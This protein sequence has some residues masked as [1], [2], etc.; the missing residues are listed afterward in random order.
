MAVFSSTMGR[1]N[2]MAGK[3]WGWGSVLECLALRNEVWSRSW[4]PGTLESLAVEDPKT[5]ESRCSPP[6]TMV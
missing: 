2:G 6:A 5:N 3:A 1:V 4:V